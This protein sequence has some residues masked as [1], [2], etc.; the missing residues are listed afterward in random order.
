MRLIV[1]GVPHELTGGSFS[2][3]QCSPVERFQKRAAYPAA[4]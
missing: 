2:H 1:E 3:E 4:S